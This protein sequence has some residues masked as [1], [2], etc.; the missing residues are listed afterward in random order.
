MFRVDDAPWVRDHIIDSS[1]LYP[2][3]GFIC[4]AI[5]AMAQMVKMQE[6]DDVTKTVIGYR[7]RDIDIQQALVVPDGD[8]GVEIQTS[9]SP[10]S[11]KAIGS[12][13]WMQFVISS[14]TTADAKWT[15]H[16]TGMIS[17]DFGA[18]GEMSNIATTGAEKKSS[19]H[20]TRAFD[21]DDF[22]SSMQSSGIKYG[23]TFQN[24]KTVVQSSKSKLSETTFGVADTPVPKSLPASHILH[25]TTLDSVIQAAYTTLSEAQLRQG[26]LKVPQSISKLWVSNGISRETGHQF[27]A[28]SSRSRGDARSMEADILVMDDD[29]KASKTVDHVLKMEGL[30]LRAVGAGIVSPERQQSKPWER[31]I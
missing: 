11:D 26:S 2:A 6:N 1:T 17:V 9:L 16:A 27:K 10:V 28:H 13:G 31:E 23:R 21:A 29:D 25:P 24:I 20:S 3:A 18:V 5:E 8:E 15:Q 12:Q 19:T 4:R 14:V 22:Y 7:L 30:V